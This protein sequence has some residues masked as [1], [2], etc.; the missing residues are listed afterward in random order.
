VDENE[1]LSLLSPY[2]K[3]EFFNFGSYPV[4]GGGRGKRMISGNLPL[5][6]EGDFVIVNISPERGGRKERAK[7][8]LYW[9]GKAI[10]LLVLANF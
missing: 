5:V 3:Q 8:T 9:S 1:L 10:L 7:R 2:R 6:K 4:I